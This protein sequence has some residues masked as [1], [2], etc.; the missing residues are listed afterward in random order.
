VWVTDSPNKAI[1]TAENPIRLREKNMSYTMQMLG[2]SNVD[3]WAA[4]AWRRPQDKDE[5]ACANRRHA[6]DQMLAMMYNKPLISDES[7]LAD[8]E[9][10]VS[11]RMSYDEHRAYLCEK[12]KERA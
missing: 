3:E 9:L 10:L 4:L 11:G 2:V 8:V 5:Q 1:K 6:S 7:F 12:Y